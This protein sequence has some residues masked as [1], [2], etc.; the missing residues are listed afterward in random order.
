M[1][2][3]DKRI[4]AYIAKAPEFAQPILSRVR[5]MVHEGAP[6]CEETLKWGHPTFIQ[7]GLLCGMLSFKGYCAVHFWKGSLFID[8]PTGDKGAAKQLGRLRSI[9]DLPSKTVFVAYVKRAVEVNAAG[10]KV[11]RMAAKPKQA[12][13]LPPDLRRAIDENPKAR[14]TYDAFSPSHRREYLEWITEAKQDS[15]RARRIAQAVEWM[16]EGKPRNWKYMK[17]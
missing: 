8:A 5:S 7:N 11:P 12:I 17:T 15:T 6:D 16:A 9:K 2:K 13:P 4:D 10:T 3:T 14:Q 1:P